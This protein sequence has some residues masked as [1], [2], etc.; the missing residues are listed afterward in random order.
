ME[1]R[2]NA[3]ANITVTQIVEDEDKY[4]VN[5]THNKVGEEERERRVQYTGCW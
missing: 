1:L 5:K 2:W 3:T 4:K